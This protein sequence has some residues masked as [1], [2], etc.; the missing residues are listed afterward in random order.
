MTS[1][2]RSE[3]DAVIELIRDTLT[4]NRK[5]NEKPDVQFVFEYKSKK[6]FTF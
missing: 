1:T 2:G 5:S 4:E 3:N 6:Y